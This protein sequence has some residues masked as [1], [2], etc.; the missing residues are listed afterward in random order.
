MG[1]APIA[2]FGVPLAIRNDST[3]Q[4]CSFFFVLVVTDL[5]LVE[6]RV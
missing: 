6:E 1:R 2:S 4:I 3:S 5:A